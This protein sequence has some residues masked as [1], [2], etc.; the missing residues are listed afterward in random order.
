[1]VKTLEDGADALYD[2]T[3]LVVP[4]AVVRPV[5]LISLLV[6]KMSADCVTPAPTKY[7]LSLALAP[8]L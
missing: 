5:L 6:M 1:M 4:S 7:N 2:F 3:E 8:I